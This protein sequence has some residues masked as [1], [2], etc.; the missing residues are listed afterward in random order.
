MAAIKDER[1]ETFTL[2]NLLEQDVFEINHIATK[3]EAE[4]DETSKH[5]HSMLNLMYSLND[6]E[7]KMQEMVNVFENTKIQDMINVFSSCFHTVENDLSTLKFHANRIEE[8]RN[9]IV[10]CLS[11]VLYPECDEVKQEPT[12]VESIWYDENLQNKC[13]FENY[14]SNVNINQS[15]FNT[16]F[17]SFVA[18]MAL[19]C[20]KYRLVSLHVCF[21]I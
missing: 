12:D 17:H 19:N 21:H 9:G 10:V 11:K 2:L 3:I 4:L 18:N 6:E 16:K 20:I 5:I 14:L 1:P 15:M 13:R 8:R 7:K